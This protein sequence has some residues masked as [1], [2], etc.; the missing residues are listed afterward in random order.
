MGAGLVD[1]DKSDYH[2]TIFHLSPSASLHNFTTPSLLFDSSLLH[3]EIEARD[4]EIASKEH[5]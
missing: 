4:S 5:T 2:L 1:G 3:S